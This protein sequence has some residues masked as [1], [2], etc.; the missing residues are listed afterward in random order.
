MGTDGSGGTDPLP[1]C[2]RGFSCGGPRSSS[3]PVPLPQEQGGR[4]PRPRR[5]AVLA[6][7]GGLDGG[8]AAAGCGRPVFLGERG[9]NNIVSP[10]EETDFLVPSSSGD[11]ARAARTGPGA[12][13]RRVVEGSSRPAPAGNPPLPGGPGSVGASPCSGSP[14]PPP[15]AFTLPSPR[16]QISSDWL[17]LQR[18][19]AGSSPRHVLVPTGVP[20]GLGGNAR[21]CPQP[22]Q[23]PAVRPYLHFVGKWDREGVGKGEG[24]QTCPDG[25]GAEVGDP[26]PFKFPC[27]RSEGLPPP[28]GWRS[29]GV[30]ST[31]LPSAVSPMGTPVS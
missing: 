30:G 18:A 14:G 17:G 8:W 27:Q 24:S 7:L 15:L 3:S 28:R 26:A 5:T 31:Q 4:G 6:A 2:P 29:S 22:G 21:Q 23:H 11:G 13:D 16:D 19:D 12:A 20:A 10:P 1:A 25:C 9:E